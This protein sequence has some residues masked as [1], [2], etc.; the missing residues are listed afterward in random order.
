[1]GS[2]GYT[3]AGELAE[4]AETRW[5]NS[6]PETKTPSG[7]VA[8]GLSGLIEGKGVDGVAN[9]VTSGMIDTKETMRTP[10]VCIVNGENIREEE[11]IYLKWQ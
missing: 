9:L 7:A 2:Q 8:A 3:A 6:Q 1:L 11:Y 10:G 5:A 4:R